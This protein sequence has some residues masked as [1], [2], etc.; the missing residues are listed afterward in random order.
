MFVAAGHPSVTRASTPGSRKTLIN[1]HFSMSDELEDIKPEGNESTDSAVSSTAEDNDAILRHKDEE[2]ARLKEHLRNQSKKKSSDESS[3]ELTTL[4]QEVKQ[5]KEL[6]SSNSERYDKPALDWMYGQEWGK[7]YQQ[8]DGIKMAAFNAEVTRLKQE[9]PAFTLDDNKM[10]YRKAAEIVR[11]KSA[12]SFE[13][14]QTLDPST[15]ALADAQRSAAAVSGGS[16][17]KD[18]VTRWDQLNTEEQKVLERF[19]VKKE[20]YK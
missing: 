9:L 5:L 4:K 12:M 13:Q 19:G 7:E 14:P 20:D 6:Y 16:V 17:R 10:I 2:I 1:N 8:D 18:D 3:D 15:S 11:I